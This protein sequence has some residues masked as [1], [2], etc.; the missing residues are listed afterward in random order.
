MT[1]PDLS[2]GGSVS[3]V[4]GELGG[5]CWWLIGSGCHLIGGGWWQ[6]VKSWRDLV[7]NGWRTDLSATNWALP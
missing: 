7:S 2:I 6:I 4:G 3:A 5:R 1:A